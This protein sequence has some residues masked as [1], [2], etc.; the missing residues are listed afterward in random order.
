MS[1]VRSVPA[2]ST[3]WAPSDSGEERPKRLEQQPD[4]QREEQGEHDA[5]SR[6]CKGGYPVRK[7]RTREFGIQV[8]G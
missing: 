4:D 2:G 8:N 6:E 7:R 1:P 5:F 3:I